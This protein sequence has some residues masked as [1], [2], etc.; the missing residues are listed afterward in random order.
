LKIKRFWFIFI[1]LIIF[2][3]IFVIGLFITQTGDTDIKL[4]TIKS[5]KELEDI[6]YG[7]AESSKDILTAIVTMPFSLLDY[8]SIRYD[9]G[10]IENSGTISSAG[11]ISPSTITADTASSSI[12]G[13]SSSSKDYSTTNI[14]VKNVDEA[15]ITK[16]DGDYIYSL[17]EYDVVIT[18]VRNPENIKVAAKISSSGN[19][20]PQEL[21]L[22]KNQL[23]IICSDSTTSSFSY[24]YANKSNTVVYVYD[25]SNHENPRL[26][27]HYTLYEPYYTS[28]L[29][30]N[31]LYVISS[32]NLRMEDNEIVTYYK[33]EYNQKEISFDHIHYLEDVKSKKQTL[34]S[35]LDLANPEKDVQV[36]SYLIDISNSYVSENNIYLFDEEYESNY[37]YA[38]PVSSLFSIFGVYGPFIY[39]EFDHYDYDDSESGYFTKVFKFEILEN[40]S[41][42]YS[43]NTKTKGRSINQYS[44]DEYN[45]NLRLAL[46]DSDGSRIVVLDKNLKE[47]G[48]TSNLAKGETMYSSRFMGNKAYL[49][50]YQTVDPLFVVD[51]SDPTNPNVLGELKIPGYSTYLHPYD[52]NHI[53]GIGMETEEKIIRNSSGLVTRTTSSI[54]GMKMALF[55]VSDVRNPKQISNT[56]IGDSRTTSAILT[57]PKALL[58]SK[59]KELIAIPVNN[60]AEDF[61]V[62][63]SAN[64]YSSLISS[65]TN[66]S[67]SYLAE[68]Y[69]VYKINLEDGFSLKGMITHDNTKN[70]KTWQTTSKLLRGLYIDNNLFTVSE[71]TIKVNDLDSLEQKAELNLTNNQTTTS[72]P[73]LTSSTTSSVGNTTSTQNISVTNAVIVETEGIEN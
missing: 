42:Q 68:G 49:V 41:I 27:K 9:T 50:T 11:A 45:G 58:F 73:T 44:F 40:G 23:I 51:L 25:V 65:Y 43:G 4:K 69:A 57:N 28:R 26:M 7:R 19:M 32:G 29:I 61:S 66:Y 59:E 5:E 33:E 1:P 31:K 36:S 72:S 54:I 21:I 53:I 3:S 20:I 39:D 35:M 46:Y 22:N 38:P 63:S 70:R 18:D 12:S 67:K 34:I 60:F 24:S 30:D 15:D 6:Y 71:T 47:I 14:Q 64:T 55:D 8:N 10:I 62:T 52:E 2:I 48:K 17:S 13:S 56:I 37:R 16:T